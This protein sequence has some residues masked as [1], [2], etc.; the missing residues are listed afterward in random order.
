MRSSLRTRLMAACTTAALVPMAI[1]GLWARSVM[2]DLAEDEHERRVASTVVS[3]RD[4]IAHRLREDRHALQQLCRRDFGLR[5]AGRALAA[6][7]GARAP[8]RWSDEAAAIRETLRVDQVEVRVVRAPDHGRGALLGAAPAPLMGTGPDPD[9]TAASL[10]AR[11]A[12]VMRPASSG[13]GRGHALVQACAWEQDATQLAV[14]AVRTLNEAF[15]RELLGDITPIRLEGPE[16]GT[17]PTEGRRRGVHTFREADGTPS[18]Q[19]VAELE[20]AQLSAQLALLDQGF[21]VAG[22][23][24][25]LFALALGALLA[26]ATT[27]PL[28]EL[29]RAAIRV[30]RGDLESTIGEVQGGEVGNALEAFN[31]MTRELKR[32]RGRLLRAERIAA[33]RDIARRI[34]HEIKNPLSPIQMSIETMRKTY[35]QGHPEFDE[36][37]EESTQAILEEVERLKRI[38]SEFSRFARM[39]RPQPERLD[40]AEVASRVV[41]LHRE[42]AARVRLSVT[43]T[44]PVLAD[45]E[46]VTQ[47]LTNLIQNALD[48]CGARHGAQGGRVDVWVGPSE[49]GRGTDVVVDDDGDGIPPADR[50]RV[51]EPYHTTKAGGT[52]LGLAIVH[53]IVLDHGGDIEVD[54]SPLGGARFRWWLPP[55]GPP[56]EADASMTDTAAPWLPRRGP[57]A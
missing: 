20:E 38:V 55:E 7:E 54:V 6:G 31:H 22:V 2:V 46:Q 10:R 4:R 44:D 14:L 47:V 41:G 25:L 40:V 36:I 3:A 35:A 28:R 15:V 33:W 50:M 13:E 48:A 45:R 43:P 37:F 57:D 51:F 21:A 53:R 8:R 23:A 29:E 52:G 27:R 17:G 19:V 39:P 11:E 56:P 12:F 34:A 5:A 49:R 32:T 42:G 26:L 24:A 18:V 9:L 1:S 30:G 16:Q